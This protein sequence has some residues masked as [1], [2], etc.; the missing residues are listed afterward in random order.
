MPIYAGWL[1]ATALI[2]AWSLVEDSY[3]LFLLG[4]ASS[5]GLL[6]YLWICALARFSSHL[7]AR[8]FVLG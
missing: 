3:A 5:L 1:T 8:F 7:Y 4:E 6:T 2:Y